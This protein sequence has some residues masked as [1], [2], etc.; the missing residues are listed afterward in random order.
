MVPEV[1]GIT[2]FMVGFQQAGNGQTR[3]A[4]VVVVLGADVLQRGG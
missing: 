4:A 3:E 2:N 1:T